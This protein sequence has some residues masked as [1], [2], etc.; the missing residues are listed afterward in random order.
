MLRE[1]MQ[2]LLM[3]L[4]LQ[5]LLLLLMLSILLLLLLEM[6]VLVLLLIVAYAITDVVDDG[7]VAVADAAAVHFAV[8]VAG[9]SVLELVLLM[10]MLMRLLMQLMLLRLILLLLPLQLLDSICYYSRQKRRSAC[11]PCSCSRN[12]S[13][14]LSAL[15]HRLNP[16]QLHS[17]RRRQLQLL[18]LRQQQQRLR[19]QRTVAQ[20][21]RAA[22]DGVILRF[23]GGLPR[24]RQ[25][26]LGGSNTRQLT[27]DCS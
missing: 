19:F 2:Q 26:Q 15:R 21:Q 11:R 10:L 9:L 4:L 17:R 1:E 20:Q 6:T 7:A 25:R 22:N 12:D 23:D 27:R 18:H 14:R 16:G 24:V 3:L 5:L 13:T 8:N